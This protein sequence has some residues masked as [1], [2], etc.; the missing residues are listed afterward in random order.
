M[1][2][3]TDPC[4]SCRAARYAP[5]IF[6]GGAFRPYG[7]AGVGEKAAAVGWRYRQDAFTKGAKL[8][9]LVSRWAAGGAAGEPKTPLR[10]FCD[11]RRK[12]A[13]G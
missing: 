8:G 13:T 7:K 10:A 6:R 9:A 1:P 5:A 12:S 3:A 2:L 4:Y 11:I